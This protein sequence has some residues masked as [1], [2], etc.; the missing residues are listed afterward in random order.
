MDFFSQSFTI[1]HFA[2]EWQEQ[3][4][5]DNSSLGICYDRN[6]MVL[7]ILIS[8][9]KIAGLELLIM[10]YEKNY[11]FSLNSSIITPFVSK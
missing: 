8:S 7:N 6:N 1:C 11:S 10:C 3:K 9:K 2:Q 4:E 5:I